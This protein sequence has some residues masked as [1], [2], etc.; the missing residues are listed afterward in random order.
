VHLYVNHDATDWLLLLLLLL[1]N[2]SAGLKEGNDIS[3][4]RGPLCLLNGPTLFLGDFASLSR[5]I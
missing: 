5:E 3:L 4:Q 2:S 1:E